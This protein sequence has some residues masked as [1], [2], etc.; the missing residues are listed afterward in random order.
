MQTLTHPLP[1]PSVTEHRVVLQLAWFTGG[2][3]L[4]FLVPFVFS[5]AVEISNDVYYGIYFVA[6]GAFLAA[7]IAANDVDM[8]ALLRR[9]WKLSVALGAVA[10][11]VVVFNVLSREESTPHPDGVYFLFT[12]AWRGLLYGAVD[13]LLLTAFPVLVAAAMLS[14]NLAGAA[15]KASFAALAIALVMIVTATYHLGYEQF[16]EDGVG[17][18]ETGN[19]IISV[20]TLLTLNPIGSVGAHASMHIA[21]DM[22]AYETDVYL[23]PQTNADD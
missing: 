15:R 13:A 16:R 19:L 11:A 3:A 5:S 6:V 12:I 14:N 17:A 4:A 8:A 18:P 1:L 2:S 21:A 7:Y 10:G 23:P 22:H 9:R 20:P